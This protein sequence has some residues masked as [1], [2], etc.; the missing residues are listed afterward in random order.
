MDGRSGPDIAA[1]CG[2]GAHNVEELACY[3]L[4]VKLRR[5]CLAIAARRVSK[6]ERRFPEDFRSAARSGASNIAE[7]FR[8]RSNREFARYLDIALASFEEVKNHR[9]PRT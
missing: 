8:R 5:A 7:G 1:S 6:E 4:A 3:Q 2:M 9:T